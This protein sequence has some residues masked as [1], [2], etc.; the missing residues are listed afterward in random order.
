MYKVIAESI[1]SATS[2]KLG[3]IFGTDI[4]RYKENITNIQYPNFFIYQVSANIEPDTRNRWN[5]NYLVNIRYRYVQDVETVTNLQENLD[6]IA[7]KLM[8]EFI[9]IKLNRILKIQNARYEKADGVLQFFFNVTVRIMRELTEEQ[10]MEI[11]QLNERLKEEDNNGR[12][13]IL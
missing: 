8:T 11:L 12:R 1:K 4:K 2:I 6:N 10:K 7:L 5:I 13:N 9:D 3:E